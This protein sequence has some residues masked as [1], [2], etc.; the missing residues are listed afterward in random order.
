MKGIVDRFEGD[1]IV[2]EID[3]VTQDIPRVIVDPGVKAGD[4][5]LLIDGKWVMDEIETRSRVKKIKELMDNVW[6]D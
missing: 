6:E 5:V 4:C 2:I 1:I 3:G